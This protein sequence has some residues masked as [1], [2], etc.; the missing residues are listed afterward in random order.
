MVMSSDAVHGYVAGCLRDGS[1]EC[2]RE[3][4]MLGISND[5]YS[6]LQQAVKLSNYL[7]KC[8]LTPPERELL[9]PEFNA[10]LA[11]ESCAESPGNNA[12]TVG[13]PR[14]GHGSPS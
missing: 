12:G 9:V 10:L 14:S 8:W 11:W 1:I 6:N 4:P 2:P 5:L 7:S 13:G 3:R